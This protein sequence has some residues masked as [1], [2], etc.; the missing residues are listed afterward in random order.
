M[1]ASGA[2]E[3]LEDP[4]NWNQMANSQKSKQYSN[5]KREVK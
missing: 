4:K 3:I 2:P 1:R 5:N